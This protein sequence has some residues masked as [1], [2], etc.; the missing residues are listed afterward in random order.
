MDGW[1]T[2]FLLGWPMCRCY[3]SF[4]EGNPLILGR[5]TLSFT[6]TPFQV[7]NAPICWGKNG[8]AQCPRDF[9]QWNPVIPKTP[10]KM[11]GGNKMCGVFPYPFWKNN[12]QVKLGII[13]PQALGIKNLKTWNQLEHQLGWSEWKC[14]T[15]C[16]CLL[17]FF[18]RFTSSQ[19]QRNDN[20]PNQL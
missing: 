14:F 1:N 6:E 9:L 13:S 15:W 18:C 16:G 10:Q 7:P 8:V 20:R 3:V 19:N 11:G 4:W 12:A 2:S 5:L 17:S